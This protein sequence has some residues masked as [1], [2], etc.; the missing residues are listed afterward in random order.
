MPLSLPLLAP[1]PN[2]TIPLPTLSPVSSA[3]QPPVSSSVPQ[4][5]ANPIA[6]S[7]TT[8]TYT[9]YTQP[10]FNDTGSPSPQDVVQGALGDCY[11]MSDLQQLARE[12][13]TFIKDH[14]TPVSNPTDPDHPN[15]AVQVYNAAGT[16]ETV[17]VDGTQ[18]S[19]PSMAVGAGGQSESGVGQGPA[20]ALWPTIYEKAFAIANDDTVVQLASGG[21]SDKA[22]E[23]LTGRAGT[24]T[25]GMVSASTLAGAM[26]DSSTAYNVNTNHAISTLSGW[27]GSS[28]TFDNGRYVLTASSQDSDVMHIVDTQSPNQE[29]WDIPV[30]HIMAVVGASSASDGSM[31]RVSLANPWGPSL[32][33][34]MNMQDIPY[35]VLQEVVA[36]TYQLPVPTSSSTGG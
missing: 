20:D 1:P 16:P 35:A 11:L 4:V 10:L 25:S 2:N 34:E 17:I 32:T 28:A 3:A 9:P 27:N 22:W 21:F 26:S 36:S 12:N 7:G 13:P 24:Q 19:V 6:P 18:L 31:V 23:T 29:S 5:S 14:I 30:D 33:N 15:Y 8:W